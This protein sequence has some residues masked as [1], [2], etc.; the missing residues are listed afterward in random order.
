IRALVSSGLVD[1]AVDSAAVLGYLAWGS[2]PPPL[3]WI[4]GVEAIAP[5]TWMRWSVDGR[6]EQQS[7]ADVDS[8]YAAHGGTYGEDE[9]R[10]RVNASVQDSVVAHLVADVPVGIFLSG[11][12]DSSAILSA[13]ARSN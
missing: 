12:I 9:L 6:R 8:V 3:T 7:F 11:G 2:V 5:G 13:A 10:E 4:S 1:R